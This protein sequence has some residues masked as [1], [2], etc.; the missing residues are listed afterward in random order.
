MSQPPLTIAFADRI[1][2][3][4]LQILNRRFREIR[5]LIRR[6]QAAATRQVVAERQRGMEPIRRLLLESFAAEER[7]M[8]ALTH[9]GYRAHRDDHETLRLRLDRLADAPV[10]PGK[11]RR[12]AIEGVLEQFIVHHYSFDAIFLPERAAPA[13]GLVRLP[14]D[15]HGEH[16][17]GRTPQRPGTR[18][19]APPAPGA[20]H[21]PNGR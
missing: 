1:A 6:L 11:G 10:S 2:A 19:L 15:P 5:V 21:E 4:P 18:L 7:L 3:E 16:H 9:F 14:A 20:A 13:H 12:G 17:G 8:T